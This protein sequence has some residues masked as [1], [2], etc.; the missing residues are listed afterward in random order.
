MASYAISSEI[1]NIRFR[2]GSHKLKCGGTL[3]RRNC[4]QLDAIGIKSI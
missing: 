1:A 4:Q 3:R 2:V